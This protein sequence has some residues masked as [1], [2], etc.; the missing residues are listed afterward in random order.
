M[1][2]LQCGEELTIEDGYDLICSKC[3]Q[4]NQQLSQGELPNE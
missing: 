4:E 1:K 2:C 3:R